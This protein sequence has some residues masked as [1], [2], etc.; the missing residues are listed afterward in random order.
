MLFR[1]QEED[2]VYF[3]IDNQLRFTRG[4]ALVDFTALDNES[5]V[6]SKFIIKDGDVILIPPKKTHV[7]VYGQVVKP[8]YVEYQ[9]GKDVSYY[10]DAAGGFGQ[11]ARTVEEISV[12]KAKTRSWKTVGKG[13]VEI[14]PGDYIWVPKQTPRTF[15]Y[16]FDLY[17]RRV[18][19][20]ATIVSTIVTIILLSRK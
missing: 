1:S 7:Y 8:G 16:Y 11:L 17:G 18:G 19:E 9:P 4:N 14:E 2:S 15:S 6:S 5:S 12:I 10:V 13:L 3:S 20:V